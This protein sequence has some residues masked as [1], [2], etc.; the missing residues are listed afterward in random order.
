[1]Q[2]VLHKL[3]LTGDN[4]GVFH[5][6][7]CGSGAKIDKVS[8]IDGKKIASFRTASPEEYETAIA[9]AHELPAGKQLGIEVPRND[10]RFAT[11]PGEF[12]QDVF[13][14]D[15]ALGGLR[16]EGVFG[17]LAFA[18]LELGKDISL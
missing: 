4:P 2:S 13:H 16:G 9:R 5:G 1:M 17:D 6:E 3:G 12:R 18:G 15:G 10:H 14:R 8:P 7:W 11:L